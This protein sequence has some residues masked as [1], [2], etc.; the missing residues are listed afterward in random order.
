M[1]PYLVDKLGNEPMHLRAA[2]AKLAKVYEQHGFRAEGGNR[3]W[4]FRNYQIPMTPPLA[5]VAAPNDP[6]VDP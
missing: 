4:T 5:T 1:V 6:S 2:T 3:S